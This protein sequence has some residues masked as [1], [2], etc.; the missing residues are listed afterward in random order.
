[1]LDCIAVLRLKE[2]IP[3]RELIREYF[4]TNEYEQIEDFLKL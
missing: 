2:V 1:M 3:D 4:M